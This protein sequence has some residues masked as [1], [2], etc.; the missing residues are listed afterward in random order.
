VVTAVVVVVDERGVVEF[1]EGDDLVA[2]ADLLGD[3]RGGVEFRR[4]QRLASGRAGNR[5]VAK[6]FVGQRRD[7]RRVD[8]A[9]EATRTP[10][11][12]ARSARRAAAFWLG[13]IARPSRRGSK[14]RCSCDCPA[15]LRWP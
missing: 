15:A 8:A 10:S 7:D 6:G 12:S 4:R 2:N 3:P 13:V 14:G 9:R 11:Q 5:P 1:G